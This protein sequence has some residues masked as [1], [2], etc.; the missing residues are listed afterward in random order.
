MLSCR[1]IFRE[2]LQMNDEAKVARLFT[3]EGSLHCY[4]RDPFL[5]SPGDL[6]KAERD[7]E[8]RAALAGCNIYVVACRRRILISPDFFF[9]G[10]LL[11]GGLLVMRGEGWVPIPF[12]LALPARLELS[13]QSTQGFVAPNGT[14]I[15][16]VD[17][18]SGKSYTIGASQIVSGAGDLLTEEDRDLQV[19]YVGQS[20]GK[21]KRRMALDRL[22]DHRTLQAILA[23]FHTFHPEME[24]I[25]LFYEFG[26]WRKIISNG[27]DLS[28]D[29][30][31]TA[32]EDRGHLN[33]IVNAQVE[34]R[35]RISLVEAA[36]INYFKPHYNVVFKQ[37]DFQGAA[38]KLKTLRAVL[39]TGLT[40]L[41]VEIG[42]ANLNS[43]LY[44]EAQPPD[45]DAYESAMYLR[46][47]HETNSSGEGAE[48]AAAFECVHRMARTH[49]AK[50]ALTTMSERETFMHGT[51]WLDAEGRVPFV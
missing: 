29:P 6:V 43:R 39:S 31:A 17:E 37:T 35:A 46:G 15:N 32:A 49:I 12:E 18:S 16:L 33:R 23:D 3:A 13:P 48:E 8:M 36:L 50:F 40:G 30:S 19:V 9:N 2:A 7:P 1:G 4:S 20:Q 41:I 25:L 38:K 42:S 34:R 11:R 26:D 44:S 27:G 28:L 45:N 10:T 24:L 14:H 22:R 21:K 51:K 5:F 47:L